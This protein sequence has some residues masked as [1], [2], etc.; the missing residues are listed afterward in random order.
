MKRESER[1][2]VVA[3]EVAVEFGGVLEAA[4][5]A[6]IVGKEF[7]RR[8]RESAKPRHAPMKRFV[9]EGRRAKKVAWRHGRARPQ[10]LGPRVHGRR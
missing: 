1:I 10:D 4:I 5:G 2:E 6:D 3:A 9:V 8:V 7:G